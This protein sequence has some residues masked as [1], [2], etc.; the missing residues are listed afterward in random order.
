M[1]PIPQVFV[2]AVSDTQLTSPLYWAQASPPHPPL[3][4]CSVQLILPVQQWC[5]DC[6]E[7]PLQIL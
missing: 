2:Q 1:H 3:L 7:L 4:H 5:I 6:L